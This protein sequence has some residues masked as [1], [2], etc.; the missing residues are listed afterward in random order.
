MNEFGKTFKDLNKNFKL[1]KKRSP[2]NYGRIM[3]DFFKQNFNLQGFMD[4]SLHRWKPLKTPEQHRI[5]IE[6]GRLMN[7]IKLSKVSFKRTVVVSNVDYAEEHN[8]GIDAPKRQFIGYS[9][10]LEKKLENQIIKDI[11][12]IFK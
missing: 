3:V 4:G 8:E 9:K 12:N 1:Y 6:S 11:E 10:T 2:R 5:L 7:S